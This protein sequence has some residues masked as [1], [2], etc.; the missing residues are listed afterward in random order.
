M[1]IQSLLSSSSMFCL[2]D[3]GLS[4]HHGTFW[5]LPVDVTTFSHLKRLIRSLEGDRKF[6]CLLIWFIQGLLCMD[7]LGVFLLDSLAMKS[8]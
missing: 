1:A 2:P 4:E 7:L 6:P 3:K 5:F 8:Q